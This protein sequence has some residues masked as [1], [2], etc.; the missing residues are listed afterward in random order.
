M[1][2]TISC[3]RAELWCLS[4]HGISNDIFGATF[5]SSPSPPHKASSTTNLESTKVNNKDNRIK[6]HSHPTV[7]STHC[8]LA[9]LHCTALH[10][11]NHSQSIYNHGFC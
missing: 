11:S 7:E 2:H 1:Y 3:Q 4:L 5:A 6:A 9:S 8:H 10:Y